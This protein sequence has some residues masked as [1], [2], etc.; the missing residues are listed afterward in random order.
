LSFNENNLKFKNTTEI[1]FN[2]EITISYGTDLTNLETRLTT[3]ENKATFRESSIDNA[4]MNNLQINLYDKITSGQKFSTAI[5]TTVHEIINLVHILNQSNTQ[6][7]V[8]ERIPDAFQSIFQYL[9]TS[10]NL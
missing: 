5:K 4:T 10:C 8:C 6:T 3:L 7:I 1:N 9:Y 2:K